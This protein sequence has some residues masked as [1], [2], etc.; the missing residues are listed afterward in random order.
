L[1]GRAVAPSLHESSPIQRARRTPGAVDKEGSGWRRAGTRSQ[2]GL[3]AALPRVPPRKGTV[4]IRRRARPGA[5]RDCRSRGAS[6]RRGG[7]RKRCWTRS[8]GPGGRQDLRR[9]RR[10]GL[11]D[12]RRRGAGR[13]VAARHRRRGQQVLPPGRRSPAGGAEE[14]GPAARRRVAHP[15]AARA[16]RRAATSPRRRRGG[17][18]GGADLLPG[19]PCGRLHSPVWFTAGSGTSTRSGL[20]RQLG[21]DLATRPPTRP[22]TPTAGRRCRLLHPELQRRP[23]VQTSTWSTTR[24]ASSYGSGSGTKLLQAARK[25]G[26]ALGRRHLQRPDEASSR[27]SI[28]PPAPPSREA[29]PAGRPRWWW[30]TRTTPRS[31]TSCSGKAREEKKVQR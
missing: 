17:L 15:C 27:C 25:D 7:P 13:L 2:T 9:R 6:P 4:T 28:A 29:S 24:R 3:Q 19:A 18:R 23:G 1:C 31:A 10:G 8:N 21:G 20:G 5:R 11:Q 30:S 16:R 14:V 26:A 12:G 22:A